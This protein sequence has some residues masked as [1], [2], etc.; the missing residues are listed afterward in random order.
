MC[1]FVF[2][3]FCY[4]LPQHLKILY[5]Y[6]LISRILSEISR[7]IAVSNGEYISLCRKAYKYVKLLHVCVN[8]EKRIRMNISLTKKEN[9]LI[10]KLANE[11]ERPYS[12]QIVYMTNFYVKNNKLRGK[13]E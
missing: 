13:M 4:S 8:M 7:I 12:R 6:S 2:E 10:K 9:G 3:T 11:E 1:D 5:P